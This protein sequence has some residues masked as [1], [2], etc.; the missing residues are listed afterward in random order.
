MHQ[1]SPAQEDF[2]FALSSLKVVN[3]LVETKLENFKEQFEKTVARKSLRMAELSIKESQS[4]IARELANSL[5]A[6]ELGG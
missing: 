1:G 3:I 6:V 2:Q 4:I 5:T